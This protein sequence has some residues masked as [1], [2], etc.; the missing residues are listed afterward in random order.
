MSIHFES[1]ANGTDSD[2]DSASSDL[3]SLATV[4]SAYMFSK[5]GD[6]FNSLDGGDI[7]EL[8]VHATEGHNEVCPMV[9]IAL[10]FFVIRHHDASVN[11]LPLSLEKTSKVILELRQ[12]LCH[13]M[14]CKKKVELNKCKKSSLGG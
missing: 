7:C 12:K 8:G 4:A 13:E 3:L 5:G 1:L 14:S 6:K 2:L 10:S 11:A 9:P